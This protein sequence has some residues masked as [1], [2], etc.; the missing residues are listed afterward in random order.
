MVYFMMIN[1]YFFKTNV[2]S[3]TDSNMIFDI[4]NDTLM[5]QFKA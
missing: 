5:E 2:C 4:R 3:Q 1:S